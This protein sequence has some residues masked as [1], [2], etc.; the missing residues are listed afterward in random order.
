MND[1]EKL[2][3]LFTEFKC[4]FVE[5]TALEECGDKVSQCGSIHK[6]KWDTKIVIDNGVGY[7]GFETEFYFLNGKF[8]NHG[9]W[10]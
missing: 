1:L 9:V 6:V 3:A 10:E 7:N 5:I 2:K 8:Q 4:G